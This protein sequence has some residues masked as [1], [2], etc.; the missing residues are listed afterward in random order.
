V[1]S[2]VET[3]SVSSAA[4]SEPMA[5]KATTHRVAAFAL[6]SV[7][8]HFMSASVTVGCPQLRPGDGAQSIGRL[9]IPGV[10]ASWPPC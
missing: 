9:E 3:T 8:V 10:I 1:L 6:I 5:V 7:E 4:M 2:A